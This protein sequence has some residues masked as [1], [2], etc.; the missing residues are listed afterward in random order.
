[1]AEKITLRI[2]D[3]VGHPIW[4]AT[5]DGQ[6]VH[7]KIVAAFNVGR[8]VELSFAARENLITAFLNA[9]IGQLYGEYDEEYI[10]SNLAFIDISEEDQS[11]VA[12]AIAN[13]K[14]YFAHKAAYD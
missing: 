13:A 7:D 9:A 3:I 12:R 10:R 4:V 6:K 1:M 11:M 8:F 14:R 5:E 2:Y